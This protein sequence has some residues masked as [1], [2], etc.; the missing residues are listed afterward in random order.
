MYHVQDGLFFE[1]VPTDGSVHI[2]VKQDDSENAPLIRSYSLSKATFDAL[3]AAIPFEEPKQSLPEEVLNTAKREVN[4]VLHSQE[5]K[6][7]IAQSA[8]RLLETELEKH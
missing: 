8:E 2:V 1:R 6:Q 4:T 7:F 5:L 3:L